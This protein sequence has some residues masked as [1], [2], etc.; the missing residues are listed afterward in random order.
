MPSLIH[1][2]AIRSTGLT[3]ALGIAERLCDLVAA[4]GVP[5]GAE[6]PLAAGPP[7]PG[8]GLDGPWWART[9]RFE[10]ERAG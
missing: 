2:A 8:L 4:A 5:L 9:A 3:A 1:A 7:P 6:A 10:A